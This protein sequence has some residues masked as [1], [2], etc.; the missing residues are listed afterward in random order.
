MRLRSLIILLLVPLSTARGQTVASRLD[1]YLTA[2]AKI[3]QFN[4]TVLVAQDGKVL[5]EKGYGFADVANRIPATAATRYEIAS[6]SKM[7]TAA[8]I[9]RLQEAG[10]LAT[11]DPICRYVERCPDAWRA[12]TIAELLHHTSGIPDYESMLDPET[13]AYL[14]YMLQ[15]NSASRILEHARTQPLDFPPGSKFRYSNTGYIL[16]GAI[17]ERVSQ[18]P[19]RTFVREH[20]LAPARLSEAT[21]ISRDSIIPRAA[22]GYVRAVDALPVVIGGITLDEHTLAS[23][24]VL[25]LDGPHGDGALVSDAHDLWR[26]TEEL[27]DSTA[28]APASIRELTTP[29]VGGYAEGWF[30][31]KEF[32]RRKLWHTGWV[33]GFVSLLEWYPESRTT[34]VVLSNVVGMR[35]S[36]IVRDLAAITFGEPYD[37]PAAHHVVPFDSAG[38]APLAGRYAFTNGDTATVSIRKAML[39]VDVPNRFSAGA[40]PIGGD[41]FYAPLFENVVRFDR[42]AHGRGARIVMEVDGVPWQGVRQE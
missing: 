32:N 42:D 38:S 22:S 25:P 37:M 24:P 30:T 29:G 36:R 2:R 11:S 27:A 34:I 15:S 5:L 14:D 35:P 39:D 8:A 19:F 20:V 3:G 17:V 13:P 1:S 33:P 21:F 23:Q 6:I 7:F 12:I 41:E 18:Q 4:G 31:G 28:L 9:L 26:W 10:K 40:L 16:L